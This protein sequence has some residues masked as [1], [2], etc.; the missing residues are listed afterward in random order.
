[1]GNPRRK[2]TKLPAKLLA[3]RLKLESSQSQMAKLLELDRGNASRV[4]EYENGK[5]EPNLIVLVRYAKLARVSLDLLA[6]DARELKFRKDWK[7][8]KRRG[9]SCGTGLG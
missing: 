8:P 7:P 5:R 4:S 2:T 9:R 6:D 3:I 1:M